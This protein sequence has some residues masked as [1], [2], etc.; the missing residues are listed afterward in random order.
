VYGNGQGAGDSP[1]QWSQESAMLFQIYQEMMDG[2]TMSNVDGDTKTKIHLT[3]FADDTNLFG[4]NDTRR[5]TRSDMIREVKDAFTKQTNS[6]INSIITIATKALTSPE[7]SRAVTVRTVRP[8][9][10][11]RMKKK[12]V[13]RDAYTCVPSQRAM[14]LRSD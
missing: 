1:S 9:I 13:L 11:I 12:D 2:A 4:N 6:R 5:K 8:L 3:A 10:T 7:L 14:V